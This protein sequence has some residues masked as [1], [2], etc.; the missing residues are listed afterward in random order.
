MFGW[1]IDQEVDVIDLAIH[2]NKLRF[3]VNAD[4]FENCPKP[5]DGLFV[6][7]LPPIFGHEDQMDMHLEN[8]VSTVSNFA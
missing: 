8:A 3:K 2:F 4:L 6:K 7:D 5:S 1:V